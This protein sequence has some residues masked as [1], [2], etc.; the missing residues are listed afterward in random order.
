MSYL[1]THS[2]LAL[3]Y[4]LPT[5]VVLGGAIVM[6]LG[7]ESELEGG[8]GIVSAGLA[9]YATNWLYRAS[10]D[11][12]RVRD[13]EEAAR[14]HFGIH[15]RWPDETPGSAEPLDGPAEPRSTGPSEGPGLGE[16]DRE[17]GRGRLARPRRS[18][19]PR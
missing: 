10:V 13:A 6:A 7:S 8:A 12:D 15:G 1:K 11:G 19:R 4:L 16:H 18:R 5:A 3:R 2:M 14:R 17:P 9:I